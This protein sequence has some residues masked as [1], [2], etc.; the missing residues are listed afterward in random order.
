MSRLY[1]TDHAI[2]RYLER[3]LHLDVEKIR[4]DIR[5]VAQ[6]SRPVESPF[7][8]KQSWTSAVMSPDEKVVSIMD[9][10]KIVTV[11]GKRE[12]GRASSWMERLEQ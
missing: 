5:A 8:R 4:E 7:Y 6:K 11:L 1:V 12:I 2:V 3:V 9:G 10:E